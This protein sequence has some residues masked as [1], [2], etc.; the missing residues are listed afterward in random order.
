MVL[1]KPLECPFY[2]THDVEPRQPFVVRS[3]ANRT[4]NLTGN[5]KVIPLFTDSFESLTQNLFAPACKIKVRTIKKIHTAI[6]SP[7]YDAQ[8][9]LLI[10][11]IV[12]EPPESR[13]DTYRCYF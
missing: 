5:H 12:P 3:L 4:P 8:T 1:L 2:F 7:F 13:T 11:L 9:C 6:Y 10:L